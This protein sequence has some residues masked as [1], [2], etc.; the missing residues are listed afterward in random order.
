M[1]AVVIVLAGIAAI[2]CLV[3]IIK[4]RDSFWEGMTFP[5]YIATLAFTRTRRRLRSFA[6][7]SQSDAYD[8]AML[9]YKIDRADVRYTSLYRDPKKHIRD[10]CRQ[11]GEPLHY[12]EYGAGLKPKRGRYTGVVR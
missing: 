4:N 1:K 10:Y 3:V 6:S 11:Y 7:E 9:W 12:S 8:H 2:R 5:I